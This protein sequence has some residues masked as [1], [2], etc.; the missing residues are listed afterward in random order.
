MG[1][2]PPRRSPT[3]RPP[4]IVRVLAITAAAFDV[5][6]HAAVVMS[7][8]FH[9][10][11]RVPNQDVSEL[12]HR[13]DLRLAKAVQVLRRFARGVVWV[14]GQLSIV[15]LETPKA[16]IEAIAYA[17]VNP[18]AEGLVHRPEDWP[19]VTTSIEDLFGGRV[20][21]ATHPG[22]YF[23]KRWAASARLALTLPACLSELGL[24]AARAML[25]AEVERQLIEARAHVKA[26]GWSVMGAVRRAASRPTARPR[27]GKRS[28][29]GPPTSRPD[30]ER[31]KRASERSSG[32][33]SS[34]SSTERPSAGGAPASATSCSPQARTCCRGPS[35]SSSLPSASGHMSGG[36]SP[37]MERLR[38]RTAWRR[39]NSS[40]LA[41]IATTAAL[42]G[43][44]SRV[45]TCAKS[46]IVIAA[47]CR[48]CWFE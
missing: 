24:D 13:L 45:D 14:P 48:T 32:C 19:G 11:I 21:S 40:E 36:S 9:L 39:T 25:V 43:G 26:Q 10:V 47:K 2:P 37:V 8:H 15:E 42:N 46:S 30:A 31:P 35:Y 38:T 22:F 18:V 16:V 6:L 3:V 41:S 12:M 5:Q 17:I 29:H 28:A 27:A 33:R 23:S 7:A 34:A 44:S 1:H 4:L 20:F